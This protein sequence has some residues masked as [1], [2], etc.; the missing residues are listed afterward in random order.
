ME[1]EVINLTTK[2]AD[3]RFVIGNT[4]AF[5]GAGDKFKWYLGSTLVGT[6]TKADVITQKLTGLTP[7][8]AYTVT[9]KVHRASDN[10]IIKTLTT[11]FITPSENLTLTVR[12]EDKTAHAIKVMLSGLTP[13]PNYVRHVEWQYK[14]VTDETFKHGVV[15]VV[16]DSKSVYS[17]GNLAANTEYVFQCKVENVSA[18][19]RSTMFIGTITAE[20][21]EEQLP[22]P[23]SSVI[24][25]PAPHFRSIKQYFKDSDDDKVYAVANVFCDTD[26]AGVVHKLYYDVNNSGSWT[27]IE[28]PNW[29]RDKTEGMGEVE[30]TLAP[31]AT[32]AVIQ[33]MYEIYDPNNRLSENPPG[34]K[35]VVSS[36]LLLRG[37][38]NWTTPKVQGNPIVITAEEWNRLVD[39]TEYVAATLGR[40]V[41]IDEVEQ[42][43]PIS[44]DTFNAVNKAIYNVITERYAKIIGYEIMN[45]KQGDVITAADVDI[46]RTAINTAYGTG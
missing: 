42:G 35:T 3:V 11:G 6:S 30:V 12:D 29:W 38:F 22:D 10:V 45:K 7:N 43:D 2:S 14:K 13:D 20:T 21:Q 27:E 19:P 34:R 40:G 26:I 31:G 16:S 25:P 41:D 23:E 5:Y 33:F 39:Y 8:T 15:F 32:S 1:L 44:A 24:V 28:Y 37:H 36:T 17:I 9:L 46:L 4:A 18:I